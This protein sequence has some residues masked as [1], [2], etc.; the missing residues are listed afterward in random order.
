MPKV[1]ATPIQGALKGRKSRHNNSMILLRRLRFLV[2]W[3]DAAVNL[4]GIPC[5]I[6]VPAAPES[7]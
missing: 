2:I 4:C 3:P 1:P 5:G 7:S 6:S